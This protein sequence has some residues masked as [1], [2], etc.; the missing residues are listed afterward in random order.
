[1]KGL[2]NF[3][4]NKKQKHVIGLRVTS[5]NYRQKEIDRV[6]IGKSCYAKL[7]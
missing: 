6:I 2:N 4:K 1:M 3:G 7:P 5:K